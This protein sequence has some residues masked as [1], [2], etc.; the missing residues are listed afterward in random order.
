MREELD[1]LGDA[2]AGGEE[3][4]EALLQ[5]FWFPM[6]QKVVEVKVEVPRGFRHGCRG[7]WTM[8]TWMPKHCMVEVAR[9]RA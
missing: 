7:H 6:I 2:S 4:D 5:V 3:T 1:A 8:S 9:F